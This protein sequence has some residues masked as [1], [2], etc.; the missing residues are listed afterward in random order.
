MKSRR[1]TLKFGLFVGIAALSML[2]PDSVLAQVTPAAT[3]QP[4]GTITGVV[5]TPDGAPAAGIRMTA[6]RADAVNDA[7]RAMASLAQTDATGR[8]RLENVPPGR[9]FVTAGRVDLPTFYPGTLDV[10]KG[11]AISI[12]S[13]A[14]VSEIDFVI[15]DPSVVPQRG[16]RGRGGRGGI[17]AANPPAIANQQIQ[18]DLNRL[19]NAL[20]NQFQGARRGPGT[21]AATPVPAAPGVA[22]TSGAAWWTNAAL[23]ARL[24]LTEEQ[25]KRI[26][27]VFDQYRQ[28]LVQTKADLDR[29]E[30]VLARMLEADSLDTTRVSSQI[31]RVVQA[32]AEMERTNSK[33]TLEIRQNLTRAQWIQLQAE[34]AQPV[35]PTQVIVGGRG[36]RSG[37]PGVRGG[38]IAPPAPVPA[39]A[40]LPEVK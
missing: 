28:S 27:G 21:T 36:G 35:A 20:N 37:G 22:T 23:V 30:G 6:L 12:T 18:D 14:V 3:S 15:Q 31:D 26:E 8:Y 9:Y 40:P 5:R 39:P 11:T 19:Q 17:G 7:L 1:T 29:E 25:K 10:A 2:A 24:G 33:M 4:A 16:G 34:T 32:R 13:A 38:V